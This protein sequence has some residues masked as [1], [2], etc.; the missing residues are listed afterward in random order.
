VQE[1]IPAVPAASIPAADDRATAREDQEG[2]QQ[3]QQQQQQLT[4]VANGQIETG[5]HQEQSEAAPD[6]SQQGGGWT[7]AAPAQPARAIDPA[8]VGPLRNITFKLKL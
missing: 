6:I 8:A 2:G 1:D 3:Q 4:A 5:G 7:E